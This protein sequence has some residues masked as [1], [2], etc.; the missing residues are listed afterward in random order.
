MY[1]FLFQQPLFEVLIGRKP[2]SYNARD[3]V[4]CA[5]A[6]DHDLVWVPFGGARDFQPRYLK[7][8]VYIDEWGTTFEHNFSAWPIDAPVVKRKIRCPQNRNLKSPLFRKNNC[9]LI[10]FPNSLRFD[11]T[12]RN[13]TNSQS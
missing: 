1:D 5:L 3:A 7:P 12:T 8:D 13:I 11:L 6:L 4:A 9:P 2:V 10:S